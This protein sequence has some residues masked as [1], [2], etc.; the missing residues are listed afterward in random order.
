MVVKTD[1][2]VKTVISVRLP[3]PMT[4]VNAVLTKLSIIDLLVVF[5]QKWCF[6]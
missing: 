6:G 5:D 1:T 3:L 2:L 4:R